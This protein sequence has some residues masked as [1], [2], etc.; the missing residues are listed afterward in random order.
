MV[1]TV[2]NMIG[3]AR[4]AGHVIS[5]DIAVRAAIECRRVKILILA[6]DTAERTSKALGALAGNAG[7]PLIV[8]GK[9]DDL[10]RILNKPP[11]AS[12]AITD[13]NFALGIIKAL[14][15]GKS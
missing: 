11:R 8:H 14:E 9:K 3:L 6:E 2:L 10:G 12:V 1:G 5:G 7:V 13:K 4:K 15:R